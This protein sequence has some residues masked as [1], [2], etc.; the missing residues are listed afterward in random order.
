M[1]SPN[2][3]RWLFAGHPSSQPDDLVKHMELGD[4]RVLSIASSEDL[5]T[6]F[7]KL[8]GF[9]LIVNAKTGVS[10]EMIELW[11]RVA[12]RQIP[13]LVIVNGLEFS[14]IDFDD[15]VLILNRVLENVI[16]PY[17]V[18]HDEMGE[19]TGLIS[20]IDEMIHDYSSGVMSE[21]PADEEL[22]SLVK[23][24]REELELATAELDESAYA[25][26]LIVPAIPFVA[27]KKIGSSEILKFAHIL[28]KR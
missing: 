8:D 14:E 13:R 18:L 4:V 20:L 2:R 28:T 11:S 15:I 21:Y 22:K 1:S 9:A 5:P 10:A 16:T 24:F 17:L 12:D 3:P 23:E 7:E 27:S 26:G 19:P 25:Q 6:E